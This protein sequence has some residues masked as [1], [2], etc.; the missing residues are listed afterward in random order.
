VD[1][2]ANSNEQNISAAGSPS[3]PKRRVH[4]WIRRWVHAI[5][6]LLIAWA[7]AAYLVLPA[8]WRHYEHHPS[9]EN[10]PKT[11]ETKTGIPGDPLNVG[12]VGTKEEVVKAFAAAHWYPADPV[13]LAS[14]LKIAEGVLLDRAYS[15]APVSTLML[16]GRRQDLAFEKPAGVSPRHRQHVRL[17]E[18]EDHGVDGRPLWIGAATYDDSVGLSHYTAQITHHVAPDVDAERDELMSDLAAAGQMAT[19]YQVTGVGLTVDGHNGGG[20]R[21]YTDGELDIGVISPGN[22]AQSEPPTELANPPAV[23]AKN[24]IWK[25]FRPLLKQTESSDNAVGEA[26]ESPSDAPPADAQNQ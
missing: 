24:R 7:L 18:S 16:W 4:P 9:L 2:P 20:D 21:Y 17:W 15:T 13:M 26:A 10:A 14:S 3:G 1:D 11:T 12:L 25:W 23:V 22:V 19:R 5:F 8:L 6:W